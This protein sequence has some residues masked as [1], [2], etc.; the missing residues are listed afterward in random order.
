MDISCLCCV[1][2]WPG[3]RELRIA[4]L[5]GLLASGS[6]GATTYV[7]PIGNSSTPT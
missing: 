1:L 2:R 4:T 5:C 3:S 6:A 7:W